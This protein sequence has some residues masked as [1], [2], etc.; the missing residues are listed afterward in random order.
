MKNN[1][2]QSWFR[3]WGQMTAFHLTESWQR[4]WSVLMSC[5]KAKVK[6]TSGPLNWHVGSN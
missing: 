2:L 5:A 6:K 3:I 4:S 1:D